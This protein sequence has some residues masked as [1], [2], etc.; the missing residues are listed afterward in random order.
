VLAAAA[1]L[2]PLT[3]FVTGP[4]LGVAAACGAQVHGDPLWALRRGARWA[5]ERG[6]AGV[7]AGGGAARRAAAPPSSSASFAGDGD[8]AGIGA[9]DWADGGWADGAADVDMV[10]ELLAEASAYLD[11]L[12][13]EQRR[14][15]GAGGSGDAPPPSSSGASAVAADL[16]ARVLK[17]LRHRRAGASAAAAE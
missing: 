13:R 6:E 4:L 14:G 12:Q 8:G 7:T 10:D 1:L 17:A 5:R 2:Q 3:P 15:P 11:A 9:G 16:G